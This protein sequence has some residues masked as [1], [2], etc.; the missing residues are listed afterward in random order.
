M[1]VNHLLNREEAGSSRWRRFRRASGAGFT[2]VELLVVIAIIGILVALLL[3]AVQA[4][5]EAARRAKCANNIRQYGIA[6]QNYHDAHKFYPQYHDS[7][8]PAPYT[9]AGTD[10]ADHTGYKWPGLTW[11]ITIMPFIEEQAL[12]DKFYENRTYGITNFTNLQILKTTIVANYVCPSNETAANPI[13]QDRGDGVGANPNV[14]LGLY[15]AVSMGPTRPDTCNFCPTP[16]GNTPPGQN[17]ASQNLNFCCQGD[18]YGTKWQDNS[19]GVLGR[20]NGKRTFKQIT[21][22]LSK[23]FLVGETRP[24]QCWYQA[25]FA[26]NFSLAGTHIPLNTFTACKTGGCHP[27]GCGFKSAHPGGAYFV[28]ADASV[29][30]VQESIDYQLYNALGTR[31]GE[32]SLELAQ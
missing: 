15:Y 3:P 17:A 9:N 24:E 5:R 27:T 8:P 29:Q 22:G 13:L 32:E 16:P 10:Y 7:I 30:F 21:D 18:G 23:T 2:L 4:A 28:M 12:Y 14:G 6:F 20:S 31:A 11:G 19:T 25:A 26:P 1:T